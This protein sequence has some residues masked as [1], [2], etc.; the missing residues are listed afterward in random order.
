MMKQELEQSVDHFKRA[1][2]LAAQETSATVGPKINAAR[3]RVQPVAEKAAGKAKDTASSGWDTALATLTPLVAAAT[4]NVRSATDQARSTGK[5]AA[6]TSKRAAK[7][8]RKKADKK[9]DKLQKRADKALGR[10]QSGGK[11]SRLVGL[12]L[13][14]AAVGAGAAYV[15]RKRKAAQWDEYEPSRPIGTPGQPAGADDAAF[16][17]TDAPITIDPTTTPSDPTIANTPTSTPAAST[18]AG[19]Q[20]KKD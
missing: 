13:I 17:P 12:A 9:A 16:E 4:E 7:A 20:F 11:A 10:K 1:A 3:D 15:M 6:K 8:N 2:T 18:P 5:T 14:G 19:E